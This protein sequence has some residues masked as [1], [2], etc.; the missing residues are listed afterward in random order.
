MKIRLNSTAL[1]PPDPIEGFRYA[2]GSEAKRQGHWWAYVDATDS[3]VFGG[4]YANLIDAFRQH[5]I[6][7]K[8]PVP[9]D[10]DGTVQEIICS[11][12][13]ANWKGGCIA[14]DEAGFSLTVTYRL[15]KRW[16]KTMAALVA[17]GT[18]VPQEEAERRANICLYCR[19]RTPITGCKGCGKSIPG[20]ITQLLINRSTPIDD[21]LTACGVCGCAIRAMVHIPN[22]TLDKGSG[23]LEYPADVGNGQPCWRKDTEQTP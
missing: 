14:T 18:L 10:I 21:Q 6:T 17:D 8:I 11:M 2:D 3:W 4:S 12:T 9:A 7:N 16:L 15:V 1:C 5:L 22:E 19:Y 20:M 13:P 23:G